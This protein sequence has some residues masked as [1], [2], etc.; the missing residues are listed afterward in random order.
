MPRENDPRTT[1]YAGSAPSYESFGVQCISKRL[2]A[3]GLNIAAVVKDGDSNGLAILKKDFPLIRNVL[4]KNHYIKKIP[5]HVSAAVKRGKAPQLRGR[6]V[7]IQ[8]QISRILG[9]VHRYEDRHIGWRKLLFGALGH[10]MVAH[11]CGDHT[12]CPTTSAPAC[13]A[14]FP[15][16][17]HFRGEWVGLNW[18]CH[19]KKD[20]KDH[21]CDL[22]PAGEE[23]TRKEKHKIIDCEAT[24]NWLLAYVAKQADRDEIMWFGSTNQN[25]GMNGKYAAKAS[26]RIDYRCGKLPHELFTRCLLCHS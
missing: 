2:K 10:Q 8:Q 9:V 6:Q 18:R 4:D 24:R 3:R 7:Q 1:L 23:K 13:L 12:K 15:A 20:K 25:E 5:E 26:K 17:T 21:S 16:Y 19:V 14:D 22:A 11:L